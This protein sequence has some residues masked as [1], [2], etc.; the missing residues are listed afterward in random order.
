MPPY[1]HLVVRAIMSVEK[2]FDSPLSSFLCMYG[3]NLIRASFT[4][5]Q[6][7]NPY[8]MHT[9]ITNHKTIYHGRP[10]PTDARKNITVLSYKKY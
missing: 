1:L 4:A 9:K 5:I 10:L 6:P 7:T 8:M 2:E 3:K